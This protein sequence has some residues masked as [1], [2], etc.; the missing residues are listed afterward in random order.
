[1]PSFEHDGLITV[2]ADI[3]YLDKQQ[4]FSASISRLIFDSDIREYSHSHN[5]FY[6][7]ELMKEITNHRNK[8]EKTVVETKESTNK[9]DS[10]RGSNKQSKKLK[11]L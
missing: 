1:M 8:K 5:K 2:Q 3:W 7:K 4:Y 10:L 6:G 11:T 9:N